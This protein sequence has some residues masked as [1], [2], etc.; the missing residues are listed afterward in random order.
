MDVRRLT[1]LRELAQRGSVT[2]VAAA[3]HLTPS[4]V[5]QQL[6]TLE[7]EAGLPLTE[8]SGRGISLTAAGRALADAAADVA[9]AIERAEATWEEFR[10][11]PRGEVTLSTFPT[12]GQMLLDGTLRRLEAQPNLRL[13]IT[14]LETA[15]VDDFA[16]LT[17][18]HDIVLADA[19]AYRDSWRRRRLVAVE[20]MHE[21]LDIALPEAHPLAARKSLRPQDVVDEPWIGVSED[22]PYDRIR[23]RIETVTRRP[24][25]VLQ[26]INDNRLVEVLVAGG[27]GIAILPRYTTRDRDGIVIR[28][29]TGVP[30][31]RIIWALIRPE[32]AVRPSVRAVVDALRAEAAQWTGAG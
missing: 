7:R 17:P 23:Q 9:I 31:E 21:P 30:N 29:L 28:P 6:K 19:H 32:R 27:H 4:A 12:A 11:T 1:L 5:S 16:D 2:A 24:A 26:R 13:V 14:D 22:F 20:L 25:R 8:R 18:D 15:G 10:G 3:L